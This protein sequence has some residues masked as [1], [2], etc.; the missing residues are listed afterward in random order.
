[1]NRRVFVGSS[2]EGL[3]YARQIC[4]LLNTE[5]DISCVMWPDIFEPGSL[6]FEALEEMLMECCA[7]VFVATPDDPG[8]IREKQ[9]L[10]PRANV[11]LE[12]GL[13]AGR[14]GRHNIAL[15][16]Y[17]VPELP[18]DLSGLT[19][20]RMPLDYATLSDVDKAVLE[21]GKAQL[22]RWCSRT[23]P[24]TERVPRTEIVHGY[25]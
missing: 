12:F 17:G 3:K 14:L 16:A 15:C 19:V 13:V 1:M 10:M 18:S 11:M 2:R 22:R 5:Q 6:T 25:T 21:G 20:I 7:A 24:T 4:D 8:V 9:V 23:L